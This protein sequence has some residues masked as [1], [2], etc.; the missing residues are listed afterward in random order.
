MGFWGK[1]PDYEQGGRLLLVILQTLPETLFY[2]MGM[3]EIK[4]SE[5]FFSKKKKNQNKKEPN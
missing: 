1:I 4:A 2:V 5:I 3:S